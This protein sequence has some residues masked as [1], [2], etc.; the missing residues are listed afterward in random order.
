MIAIRNDNRLL[1]WGFNSNGQ[2]G[3]N[4]IVNQYVPTLIGSSNWIDVSAGNDHCLAIRN[5][6][7]LFAWGGNTHGQVGNNSTTRVLSP[8]QIGTS[9]WQ[10]VHAGFNYSL[11]IRSDGKLFAWGDGR[12]G[13]L[14]VASI[15]NLTVKRSLVPLQVGTNTW[16]KASAGIYNSLGIRN[17]GILFKW[18]AEVPVG[19]VVLDKFTPTQI[20]ND[21][22]IDISC[23]E[24][25][26]CIRSDN[27]LFSFGSNRFGQLGLNNNRTD[28]S[29]LT[30]VGN[31]KW[32]K[33]SAGY[34]HSLGITTNGELYSWGWNDKGELGLGDRNLRESP[35]LVNNEIT[36]NIAAGNIQSAI[37]SD[38]VNTP[39]PPPPPPPTPPPPP[40]PPPPSSAIL[41][42]AASIANNSALKIVYTRTNGT[43]ITFGNLM[44]Q[45]AARWNKYLVYNIGVV[46]GIRNWIRGTGEPDWTKWA[47]LAITPPRSDLP[48]PVEIYNDPNDNTIA[49]CGVYDWFNVNNGVQKNAATYFLGINIAYLNDYTDANW[50]DILTHELGHALGI[51]IF[52][53]P[54]FQP[55][56][57]VPPVNNFLSGASY[58]LAQ[59]AYNTLL[60][61]NTLNRISLE[62]TGGAGTTSGHWND[63]LK[64]DSG[65]RYP[66]FANELMIGYFNTTV[67]PLISQLSID[68]LVNFGYVEKS[69]GT[70][71]GTPTLVNTAFKASSLTGVRL[72]CGANKHKFIGN[73]VGNIILH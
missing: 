13:Q 50:I 49:Y 15:Q 59:A 37:I 1:T 5:D 9:S 2:L 17:D 53:D 8:I 48:K 73:Y 57:A 63:T 33:I 44:S 36:T 52:W 27:T 34:Y 51:G 38:T 10:S 23:S 18:G 43:Q 71:E 72:T 11:A 32:N 14:G 56:G 25:F 30:Q 54:F 21:A 7:K 65:I 3:N 69:P 47:G 12:R 42:D 31:L 64:I 24:H 4:S 28:R 22:W 46:D 68:A 66:G 61:N 40:P 67:K 41:F 29:T 58:P 60:S 19:G 45:S 55:Y 16:S 62:D 26:L 6:G 39:P 20:S 35:V 70:N